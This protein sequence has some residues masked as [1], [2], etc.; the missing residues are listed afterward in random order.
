LTTATSSVLGMPV[1]VALP[2]QRHHPGLVMALSGAEL[3]AL[4]VLVITADGAALLALAAVAIGLV[5]QAA[6]NRR[7]ILAITSGG[8]AL[9][10]ASARGRPLVPLG[11]APADLSLPAPAGLGVQVVLNGAS[12]WVERSSFARLRQ[13]RELLGNDKGDR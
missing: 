10:A 5:A 13:A 6:T 7:R 8:V 3:A 11:P 9:L 1:G 12:W 2:I 4:A